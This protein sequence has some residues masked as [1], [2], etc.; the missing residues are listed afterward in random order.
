MMI[1]KNCKNYKLI[2][3][4]FRNNFSLFSEGVNEKIYSYIGCSN[5][6]DRVRYLEYDVSVLIYGLVDNNDYPEYRDIILKVLR[7]F[8]TNFCIENIY[9]NIYEDEVE[10]YENEFCAKYS[11][12]YDKQI[13]DKFED[14]YKHYFNKDKLKELRQLLIER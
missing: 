8:D 3:Y 9:S 10:D 12:L 13:Y 1:L 11:E 14:V 5:C 6:V 7:G 2:H 4:Q